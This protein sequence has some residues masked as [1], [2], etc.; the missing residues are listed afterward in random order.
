MGP[1]EIRHQLSHASVNHCLP[2]A[3]VAE[4]VCARCSIQ[5][6]DFDTVSTC[7]YQL[8]TETAMGRLY[9]QLICD[10]REESTPLECA[11]LQVFSSFLCDEICNFNSSLYYSGSDYLKWCYLEGKLL[12]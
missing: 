6:G 11:I 3:Q 10:V 12:A 8:P 4:E 9:Q 1:D 7:R 2:L 5:T